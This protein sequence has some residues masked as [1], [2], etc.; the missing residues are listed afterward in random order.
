MTTD[1]LTRSAS[2]AARLADVWEEFEEQLS[3][4]PILQ[5][6]AQAD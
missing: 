6:L 5:R 1:T 4:V 2:L 3:R